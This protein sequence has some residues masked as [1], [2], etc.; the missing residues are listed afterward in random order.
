MKSVKKRLRGGEQTAKGVKDAKVHPQAGAN[1]EG[2]EGREGRINREEGEAH[3]DT[4]SGRSNREGR[5]EHEGP[6]FSG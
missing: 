5:E 3:E 6:P 1:R 2:R 4:P